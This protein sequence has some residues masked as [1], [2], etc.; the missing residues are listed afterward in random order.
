MSPI[1][2]AF[3]ILFVAPYTMYFLGLLA[4]NAVGKALRW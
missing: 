3:I 2:S 1:I 4:I